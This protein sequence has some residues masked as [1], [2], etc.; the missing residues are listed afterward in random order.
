MKIRRNILRSDRG[1]DNP[2]RNHEINIMKMIVAET[3]SRNAVVFHHNMFLHY[4]GFKHDPYLPSKSGANALQVT[5][6]AKKG[7]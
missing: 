6:I 5:F 3:K 1:T 2:L 4:L 7:V